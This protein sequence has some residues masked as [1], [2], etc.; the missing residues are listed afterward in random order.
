MAKA[1]V[2]RRVVAE[3]NRA[4]PGSDALSCADV[5]LL[6]PPSAQNL[7]KGPWAL[8][9]MA[10][11]HAMELGRR[12]LWRAVRKANKSLV[13]LTAPEAAELVTCTSARAAIWL[14]ALLQDFADL[15]DI[16]KGWDDVQADHPCIGIISS[17]TGDAEPR[18]CLNRPVA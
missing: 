2:A 8:I 5:W 16:P 13:P 18:L 17:A 12:H 6:S 4:L 14:W 9:C 3:I 11:L 7:H 1:V 15:Q 10:A